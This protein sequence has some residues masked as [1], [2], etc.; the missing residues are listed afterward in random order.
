VSRELQKA[1]GRFVPPALLE[2]QIAQT[3]TELLAADGWRCLITDPVSDRTRGKGFGELG[4]A[5]RLYIRYCPM[6]SEWHSDKQ[7]YWRPKA[8]C[9][10]L[11]L[12]IEWKRVDGRG[13]T[14]KATDHQNAWHAAERARGALTLIAGVDFPATIE[15]FRDWYTRSGLARGRAV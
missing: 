14:T 7:P 12:W 1:A 11:V 15:G 2:S 5:D 4:M 13:R 9:E 10:A 6:P 8:Q 3:C